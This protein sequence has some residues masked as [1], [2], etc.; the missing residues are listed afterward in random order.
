M[1]K[2]E[3]DGMRMKEDESID[4]FAGRLTGMSVKYGNL[5]GHWMMRRW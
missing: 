1:L 4:G 2:S 3:F 5:G